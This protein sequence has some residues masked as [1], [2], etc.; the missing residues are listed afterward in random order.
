MIRYG[1]VWLALVHYNLQIKAIGYGWV[2]LA[3]VCYILQ[4]KWLGLIRFCLLQPATKVIGFDQLWSAT[5][6]KEKWLGLISFGFDW[7]WSATTC[8]EKWSGMVG[9]DHG[10]G[11]LQPAKK[12]DQVW[13]GL[14]SFGLLQPAKKTDWVWLGLINFGLLQPA[15]KVIGFDHLWSTTTCK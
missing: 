7:L 1:W 14:I 4:L 10:F 2:W 13:L 6:C 5:T 11:L 12:S 15:T 9:F 3:L 8:K